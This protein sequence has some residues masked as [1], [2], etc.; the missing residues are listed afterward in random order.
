MK[1]LQYFRNFLKLLKILGILRN[2]WSNQEFYEITEIFRNFAKLLV[3]QLNFTVTFAHG[4]TLLIYSHIPCSQAVHVFECETYIKLMPYC[5]KHCITRYCYTY[6][7]YW[8]TQNIPWCTVHIYHS[9]SNW[10]CLSKCI[11]FFNIGDIMIFFHKIF[12]WF[13][14]IEMIL[15]GQLLRR[16]RQELELFLWFELSNTRIEIHPH[17]KTRQTPSVQDGWRFRY[18]WFG[19]SVQWRV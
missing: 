9:G 14:V 16:G 5:Q 11:L 13:N 2:Y 10:V 1:F 12:F 3:T 18:G 8:Y 17:F 15:K 4:H 7:V 6:M 19:K